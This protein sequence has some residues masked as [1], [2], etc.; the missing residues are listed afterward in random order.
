[1]FLMKPSTIS[2]PT[3]LPPKYHSSVAS[4][5]SDVIGFR[6]GLP[7]V[8]SDVPVGIQ[9]EGQEVPDV[10]EARTGEV[11]AGRKSEHRSLLNPNL[12]FTLGSQ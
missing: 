12:R 8:A 6:Y 5:L 4:K 11:A 7:A 1:M 3:R 2:E 9:S 10:A